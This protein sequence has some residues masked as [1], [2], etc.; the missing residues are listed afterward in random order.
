MTST[1]LPPP[2]DR[3]ES[4]PEA[5]ALYNPALGRQ[6]PGNALNLAELPGGD[7]NGTSAGAAALGLN[8]VALPN[9]NGEPTP[10][11]SANFALLVG[12]PL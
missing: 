12:P 2:L 4:A 8:N 3:T 6:V 11:L 10:Y 1:R 5:T 9:P 7:A